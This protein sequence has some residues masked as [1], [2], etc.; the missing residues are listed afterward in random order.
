MTRDQNDR[1]TRLIVVLP[2]ELAD[3]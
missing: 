2:E 3:V 1:A